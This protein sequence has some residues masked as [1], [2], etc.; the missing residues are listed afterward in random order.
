[1]AAG[2]FLPPRADQ[3]LE[4]FPLFEEAAEQGGEALPGALLS[5]KGVVHGLLYGHVP[6]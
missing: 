3:L 4:T 6:R 2:P 5:R 1:M